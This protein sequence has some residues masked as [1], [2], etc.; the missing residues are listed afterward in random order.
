MVMSLITGIISGIISGW[1]VT[2]Y[3]RKIDQRKEEREKRLQY[4]DMFNWYLNELIAETNIAEKMKEDEKYTEI[5]RM[6]RKRTDY[7][8]KI[9]SVINESAK[10]TFQRIEQKFSGIEKEINNKN[11]SIADIKK[12]IRNIQIMMLEVV[13]INMN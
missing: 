7:V 11:I 8:E 12:E 10:Q 6:L 4:Y 2:E 3:Y 13:A 1:L 5:Y 9:Y